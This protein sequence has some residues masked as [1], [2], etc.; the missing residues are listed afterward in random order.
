MSEESKTDALSDYLMGEP[1]QTTLE[2]EYLSPQ[3]LDDI[4]VMG[5]WNN[6]LPERMDMDFTPDGQFR[7]FIETVVPL[8][9]K[10]RF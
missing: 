7:Y 9:Y 10:Y 2:V 5:E 3:M 1:A 4:M 6:W 8:G